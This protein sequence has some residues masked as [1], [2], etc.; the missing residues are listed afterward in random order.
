MALET[1]VFLSSCLLEALLGEQESSVSPHG[2]VCLDM[3]VVE[4][5]ALLLCLGLLW[6]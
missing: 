2:P 1:S 6:L 4:K 5:P 3:L